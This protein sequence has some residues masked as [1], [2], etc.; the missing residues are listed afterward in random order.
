MVEA[1][2]HWVLGMPLFLPSCGKDSLFSL[3][4]M[5]IYRNPNNGNFTLMLIHPKRNLSQENQS[6]YFNLFLKRLQLN[7]SDTYGQVKEEPGPVD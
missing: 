1:K 4:C 2:T 3:I 7:I 6:N 5:E